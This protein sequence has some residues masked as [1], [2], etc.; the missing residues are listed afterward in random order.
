MSVSSQSQP[1]LGKRK[2]LMWDVVSNIVRDRLML[3]GTL[4]SARPHDVKLVFSS[5]ISLVEL[6]HIPPQN[7]S[8]TFLHFHLKC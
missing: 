4:M 7:V 6:F 1:D 2:L 5:F 3:M 8:F